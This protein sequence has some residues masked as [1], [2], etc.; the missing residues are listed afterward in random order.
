MSAAAKPAYLII[1]ADDYGYFDC[2]SRGI[3]YAATQ[4][5]VTATGVMATSPRLSQQWAWLR[6]SAD[7]DIGIHLNLTWGSPLTLDMKKK[8][9]CRNGRFP[10]KRHIVQSLLIGRIKKEEIEKEWRAQI[11][12]CLLLGMPLRFINSHEHIHMF[13]PLYQRVVALANEYQISHVRFVASDKFV[14]SSG[15]VLARS[16]ALDIC[17]RL[18]R[19][20]MCKATP[21]MLGLSSSGKLGPSCLERL[22]SHLQPYGI[23]ELMCHPGFFN[24]SEIRCGVLRRYHDWE[25]EL[26]LLTCR[27]TRERLQRR[28]IEIVGY[29]HLDALKS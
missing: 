3:I 25:G 10:G 13:P 1:N 8:L 2:V 22:T 24:A 9:L 19:K 7:V 5:M 17:N 12:K 16:V 21:Q 6:E 27:K 18:N 28:N 20:F 4:G 15:S 26:R 14:L 11:E 23:Y 29:R